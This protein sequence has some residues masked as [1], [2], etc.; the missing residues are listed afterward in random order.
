MTQSSEPDLRFDRAEYAKDGEK[1]APCSMCKGPLAGSYW[2]WQQHI[3]CAGCR[4]RLE[5]SLAESQSGARLAK[6]ALQGGAAALACGIAY[7]IFVATTKMQFALATIGIAYVVARVLR[8]ASGGVGGRRFQI[9]AVALT[10]VAATM[11]Y[12]PGIWAGL[13]EASAKRAKVEASPEPAGEQADAQEHPAPQRSIGAVIV[14]VGFLVGIML[15]APFLELTHAPLGL[16]I[17]AFGLWEAWRLSRAPPLRVE[18]PFQV[19]ATPAGP[20]AA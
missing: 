10:Y 20:R 12:A 1:A 11:G 9:L 14:A 8:K 13:K 2:K 15:A 19:G 4:A 16:L 18:G 5:A 3:V 6:A 7:A 17:V